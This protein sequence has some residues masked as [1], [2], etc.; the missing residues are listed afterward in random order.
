M[1]FGGDGDEQKS[2]DVRRAAT[3]WAG[4]RAPSSERD[5]GGAAR[6]RVGGVPSCFLYSFILSTVLTFCL[7]SLVVVC[8]L[9]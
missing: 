2:R 3:G 9:S 7:F 6:G 5:G 8:K 4:G 1:R